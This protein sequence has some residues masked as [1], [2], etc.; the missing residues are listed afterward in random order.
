MNPLEQDFIKKEIMRKESE[1]MRE[2]YVFF[3]NE[4]VP[5]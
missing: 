3:G 5:N 1:K 2:K 4:G